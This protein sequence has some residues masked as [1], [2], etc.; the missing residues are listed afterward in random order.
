[1]DWTQIVV[2]AISGGA[3]MKVLDYILGGRKKD[4]MD[5]MQIELSRM[6]QRVARL[7]RLVEK[8]EM[9]EAIFSSATSCAHKCQ[10]PDE[11]CPVLLYMEKNPLPDKKVD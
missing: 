9:R 3:L 1:M 2:A 4:N 7:E 5:V 8:Y 11:E 6:D 10:V